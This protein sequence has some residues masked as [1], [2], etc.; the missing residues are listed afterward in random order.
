MIL[1][2]PGISWHQVTHL[3]GYD[4]TRDQVLGGDAAEFTV[5][6]HPR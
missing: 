1:K 4:I 3:Q 5:T 2:E 6:N